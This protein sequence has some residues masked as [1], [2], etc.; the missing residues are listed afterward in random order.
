MKPTY[1]ELEERN[2]QLEKELIASHEL[3]D[4][5][6]DITWKMDL[7]LKFTYI[8]RSIIGA[9]GYQPEEWLS[10]KLSAHVS[11]KQFIFIAKKILMVLKK[12]KNAEDNVV[13]EGLLPHKNGHFVDV[14]IA[15]KFLYH[16]DGTPREIIGNTRVITL[17]KVAERA[18]AQKTQLLKE[19]NAAKDKF[20]TIV[21]HDLRNPFNALIGFSDL[22]E[23]EVKNSSNARIIQ[24]SSIINETIKHSFD[25]LNNLLEWSRLQ[26]KSI[27][28]TPTEF[29]LS[30][31]TLEVTNILTLQAQNKRITISTDVN[32]STYMKADR[33]MI[34]TVLMNLLSNAIKYCYK[35][36]KIRTAA[37]QDHEKVTFNIQDDGMGMDAE[38]C[39]KLFHI[40][41][42]FSNFGTYNESGTGLGL[43]LCKEFISKH[44]GEIGVDSVAGKGSN[45]WFTIPIV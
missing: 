29:Q 14:E 35:D 45:F 25:Y 28:Y 16:Q 11:F 40:E 39:D 37:S 38:T 8:S 21:A 26:T 22:L 4:E 6:L 41:K 24:F 17:R 18:L 43:I 30:E 7:D 12:H 27:K 1:Q 31:L 20:F 23:T 42:S 9:L 10:N 15:G 32:T 13:F 5:S 34:K 19:S 36:G 33:N 2:K 3:L 44:N